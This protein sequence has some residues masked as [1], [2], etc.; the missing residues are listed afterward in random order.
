M[1]VNP[2]IFFIAGVS[3][4][5]TNTG[6]STSQ[7]L[8]GK[9]LQDFFT[10]NPQDCFDRCDANSLCIGQDI[11][12]IVNNVYRC[13]LLT[14]SDKFITEQQQILSGALVSNSSCFAS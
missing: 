6:L 7:R 9:V 5:L 8:S 12:Q 1:E 13:L 11:H 10:S 4:A 3:Y 2:Q 14:V